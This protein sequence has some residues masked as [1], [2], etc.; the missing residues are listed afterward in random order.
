MLGVVRVRQPERNNNTNI[1][2]VTSI[3]SKQ[4]GQQQQVHTTLDCLAIK[5]DKL[6]VNRKKS[7]AK[8]HTFLKTHVYCEEVTTINYTA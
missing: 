1:E 8:L 4:V 5:L 2:D 6:S 3:R 7:T